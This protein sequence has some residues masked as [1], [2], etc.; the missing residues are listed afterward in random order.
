MLSRRFRMHAGLPSCKHSELKA[1]DGTGG[2]QAGV[3][4]DAK[5]APACSEH[6]VGNAIASAA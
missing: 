2:Q 4:P 6:P 1:H 3:Q 5:S